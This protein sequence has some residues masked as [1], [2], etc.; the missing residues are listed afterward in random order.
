MASNSTPNRPQRIVRERR[1]PPVPGDDGGVN[2]V[3]Q[4]PIDQIDVTFI[5]TLSV[6]GIL[7]GAILGGALGLLAALLPQV[8]W[9]MGLMIGAIVGGTAL[10]FV[11]ARPG[12]RRLEPQ[13]YPKGSTT[14][15]S[16][17][18]QRDGRSRASR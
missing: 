3:K 11:L 7:A 14:T 8:N 2:R 18:M 9:W 4:Q 12:L 13:S 5:G 10:A 6:M 17:R 15:A 1:H 16:P